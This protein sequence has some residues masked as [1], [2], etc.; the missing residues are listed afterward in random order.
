MFKITGKALIDIGKDLGSV[1][2][3][4]KE[5]TKEMP[6]EER[7]KALKE[8]M[9]AQGS[10]GQAMV[11]ITR[12]AKEPVNG[13]TIVKDKKGKYSASKTEIKEDFKKFIDDEKAFD[14]AISSSKINL[15][16]LGKK[17]IPLKYNRDSFIQDISK[18]LDK[19]SPQERP[20]IEE[21]FGIKLNKTEFNNEKLEFEGIPHLP[22][23]IGSTPNEI[24]I[25]NLIKKFTEGNEV[26]LPAGETK[27][28]LDTIIQNF[29]EFTAII[30][31]KQHHT[32]AFSVDVHTL[33]VLQSCI[34][35]PK[36]T[37]L[38]KDSKTVLKFTTI[39]HDLGKRF[40]A[41][42]TPD[43]GHAIRST[44]FAKDILERFDLTPEIKDRI[45]KQIQNHH[46]FEGFNKGTTTAEDVAKT[47]GTK[48]DFAVAKIIAKSDYSS[49]NKNFHL[50]KFRAH[51]SEDKTDIMSNEEF[52]NFIHKSFSKVD[53]VFNSKIKEVPKAK[54]LELKIPTIEEIIP[55]D[56]TLD[57]AINILKNQQG[58]EFK[59]IDI[60][61]LKTY[62]TKEPTK[63]KYLNNLLSAKDIPAESY[64][65]L[66][67]S[68]SKE[69]LDNIKYFEML[70]KEI[71]H[72]DL[73]LDTIAT[74][75]LLLNNGLSLDAL[76]PYLKAKQLNQHI[77]MT[78]DILTLNIE[79]NPQLQKILQITPKNL[80]D[81]SFKD[82]DKLDFNVLQNRIQLLSKAKENSNLGT[83]FID[84]FL[85]CEDKEK[86]ELLEKM[87]TEKLN[88]TRNGDTKVPTYFDMILGYNFNLKDLSVAQLKEKLSILKQMDSIKFKDEDGVE[89]TLTSH[90]HS[91]N[92]YSFNS[93]FK[94]YNDNENIKPKLELFKELAQLSKQDK[95]LE[96]SI[97]KILNSPNSYYVLG[98]SNKI[99]FSAK[100]LLSYL[101]KMR[102]VDSGYEIQLDSLNKK[103][104]L[105]H[106]NSIDFLSSIHIPNGKEKP[107]SLLTMFKPKDILDLGIS[108]PTEIR[109]FI[110]KNQSKIINRKCNF[111]Q[112]INVI[113]EGNPEKISYLEKSVLSKGENLRPEN[114]GF[115]IKTYDDYTLYTSGL[116]DTRGDFYSKNPFE[117]WNKT[118]NILEQ[119]AR[120]SYELAESG[121]SQDTIGYM[122][123]NDN[124]KSTEEKIKFVKE[125]TDLK[126]STELKSHMLM[127]SS[128]K[129]LEILKKAKQIP[130]LKDISAEELINNISSPEQIDLLLKAVENGQYSKEEALNIA[131]I[132]NIKT[133][134][135][136]EKV[137]NDKIR[138]YS[139]KDCKMLH[140]IQREQADNPELIN[141]LIKNKDLSFEDFSSY[142]A[143]NI[144]AKGLAKEQKEAINKLVE[145]ANKENIEFIRDSICTIQNMNPEQLSKLDIDSFIQIIKDSKQIDK[146]ILL[147]I[148][149]ESLYGNVSIKNFN[150]IN[151]KLENEFIKIGNKNISLKEYLPQDYILELSRNAINE[152]GI[153]N[154]SFMDSAITILKK[155]TIGHKYIPE[156][157]NTCLKNDKTVDKTTLSK[158]FELNSK[159]VTDKTIAPFINAVKDGNGKF[160]LKTYKY[161]VEK[162]NL[163]DLTIEDTELLGSFAKYKDYKSIHEM[164]KKDKKQFLL[165]L[166]INKSNISNNHIKSAIPLIPA[167]EKDYVK[168]M[169]SISQSLNLSFKPLT[170]LE[171]KEFDTS[172][173][174]LSKSLK[175]M[176]L[177][178]LSEIKLSMPHSEFISKVK[179]TMK[180]LAPEEQAKIEDYFGFHIQ[181][182]KLTGYPNG[183]AKDIALSD[184]TDKKSI[185]IIEKL[186]P[187]VDKY[188]SNNFI[189]IKDN[190]ELNQQLKKISKYMPEIFNQV[191]G[192]KTA[193]DTIKT[194]QKIV[195]NPTFEKLSDS[196]KKVMLI[197]T[198]LH[199]TD[200]VSKDTAESAFDAYFIAKKF[201]TTDAEAKKIYKI[202]ESSDLINKFMKTTK[203]KTIWESR[204]LTIEGENRQNTFDLLAFKLKEGNDFKLA[205]MLYSSKDQPKLTRFLDKSLAKRIEEIKSQDFILPQTASEDYLKY[206]KEQVI[207]HKGKRYKV[208]VTSAQ[209]LPDFKAFT[210]TPDAAVATG[211]TRAMN[212]ANFD[213]F[214]TLADDKII[215]T[216]YLSKDNYGTFGVGNGFIFDVP[217]ESQ[218][219]GYGH[220]IFSL[221][222]DEPHMLQE[223]Y[224]DKGILAER[225]RG[226]KF[227][228]RTM[229]S[230]NLKEIMG[231]SDEEYAKRLDSLKFK[232]GKETLTAE[233]L[234]EFDPELYDAYYNEFFARTGSDNSLLR[235]NWHNE[236]LVSNP[237]I[238]AIYTKDLD[239]L[240]EDYLIKAQEEG[241]PIVLLN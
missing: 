240:P 201:N 212:F 101:K 18:E 213:A 156:I 36:Y 233:K 125:L 186:K 184:I 38:D 132:F 119:K 234:K 47:F 224:R 177:T 160:D 117:L 58:L 129:D 75:T 23:E 136:A 139:V 94:Y 17:G 82:L 115:Q 230:D 182:G 196:D 63:I 6:T 22:K 185:D 4:A 37:K 211:G 217:T 220:D 3:A 20:I 219:V 57:E 43:A 85:R 164:P 203:E 147:E 19:L 39:L 146:N 225:N 14:E 131:G 29:P 167:E 232:V 74:H 25:S 183:E 48:E 174:E 152:K 181:N 218:Y 113:N 65:D 13:K 106:E 11:N 188:T 10:Q 77:P 176:N 123:P 49:I 210:H 235:D 207:E 120:E 121:L 100:E 226:Q 84:S 159:G 44:E 229:I 202:V 145:H 76:K 59:D 26:N 80:I 197:S 21:K 124:F 173:K 66:L 172:L 103:D 198:L 206:G 149:E 114:A 166:L 134:E 52:D 231:I 8:T 105:R 150:K 130:Q 35:N 222:K 95:E 104:M 90:F 7:E 60:A 97:L 151:N 24:N 30:G 45:L 109:E 200:K 5:I 161:F 46:W 180:D 179:D 154:E 190:P 81:L 15:T 199:N 133:K 148:F 93:T 128:M 193:V 143:L 68:V 208:I 236:V 205:Q 209:D 96:P 170:E 195:Q 54:N 144:R 162:L 2:N 107:Q 112:L 155:K 204:G 70:A 28:L 223:Y 31:K 140:N 214:K 89:K 137:L 138:K 175:D 165:D 135:V 116:K 12:K 171:Q 56:A 34:E 99:D 221:A 141:S 83:S 40:I 55:K 216:S 168:A 50:N 64:T 53:E 67:K 238:T 72:T 228:H 69:R 163:K 62:L 189:T 16:K 79:N 122:H 102:A 51:M 98:G 239:K 215:C 33:K 92:S 194:L 42:R 73:T 142:L 86:T 187:I 87:L 126:I 153:I 169:K 61:E 127:N 41:D 1:K 71:S 158:V 237:K 178:S 110:V 118:P 108:K 227:G 157:L 27:N 78:S 91:K 191:D 192:S 111:K 9:S 32:Q 88:I 241:L